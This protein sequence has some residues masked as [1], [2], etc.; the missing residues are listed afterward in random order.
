MAFIVTGVATISDVRDGVSPPTIYLTN[1]NHT[2]PADADGS[3]SSFTGFTTA[4][5]CFVGTTAYAYQAGSGATTGTN[6]RIGTPTVLPSGAD[7]TVSTDSSGN[8][9]VTDGDS[10]TSG[11]A[12]GETHNEF[13]VTVPVTV[14]GFGTTTFNRV[15]S[16][17]K[18]IGGSAPIVRVTSNTQTVEYNQAGT[19]ARTANIVVTADELNFIDTGDVTWEWRSGST[20]SFSAM[21]GASGVTLVTT[22]PET[23]TITPAGFNTFLA[24]NR[25][26]TIRARRG[27]S[28]ATPTLY[29]QITI[30]RVNDGEAAITVVI[31]TTS[32]SNILKA[33]TDSV[34]L[35]A[36]VYQ[37]GT[38]LTPGGD[39]T[40]LW[41]KDGTALN[42]TTAGGTVTAGT[43]TGAIQ[44][45]GHGF[46]QRSLVIEGD[47]IT[48]N[49]SSLFSC[50]VT[51]PT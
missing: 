21:S 14:G 28:L 6:F 9:T 40:Y 4:V 27:G 29:D 26:V 36:D 19:V 2:F 31:N 51:D 5:Q 16:F 32:G 33:D 46:D 7:I 13:T 17:S 47:G 42:A 49:A 39:W 44:P 22:T 23:A 24:A 25:T 12:D 45:T 41:S 50:T 15:I 43:G 11:F 35:R 30:A 10:V 38:L 8:I 18:S 37:A 48:D 34:T 20:G 3:V 1:E